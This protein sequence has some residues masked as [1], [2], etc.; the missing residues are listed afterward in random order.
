MCVRLHLSV[1]ARNP[2]R[3]SSS[4]AV[5]LSV[6][7]NPEL[8]DTGRLALEPWGSLSSPALGCTLA[9]MAFHM[10]AGG[11]DSV[12]HVSTAS[13]S[14]AE[15]SPQSQVVQATY[16]SEKN[17]LEASNYCSEEGESC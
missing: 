6:S 13:T 12:P 14:L 7:L 10:G 2:C 3:P 16:G 15:P 9:Y 5:H 17:L 8:V 1:E 11:L 4:I